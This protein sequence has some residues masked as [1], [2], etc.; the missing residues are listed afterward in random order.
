[1]AK[2]TMKCFFIAS[3][4]L[5]GVLIG[6]QQANEGMK[7]MKGYEDPSLQ[8]AFQISSETSGE[9]EASV[10]GNKVTSHDLDEKQKQLEEVEAF[11]FFSMMGRKLGEGVS[12][13]FEVILTEVSKGIGKAIDQIG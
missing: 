8:S 5:I 1:M 6:M 11:N 10:L 9:V 4:L 2:F 3:V 7:K 12:A 13:V